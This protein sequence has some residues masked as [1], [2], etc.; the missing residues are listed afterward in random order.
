MK[1]EGALKLYMALYTLALGKGAYF[2][3]YVYVQ[4]LTQ[5]PSVTTEITSC[6]C[7]LNGQ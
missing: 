4:L 7:T 5:L 3:L 2:S 1:L 6:S